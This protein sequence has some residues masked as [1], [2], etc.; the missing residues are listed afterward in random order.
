MELD[1]QWAAVFVAIAAL[2][3]AIAAYV[4]SHQAFE[5]SYRP[6]LRAIPAKA[7]PHVLILKN[8][9]RGAAVSVLIVEGSGA[10]E[11]G[12]IGQVDAIEPLGETYGPDHKESARV[13]RVTAELT[14]KLVVGAHYRV[15]Y[16]DVKGEW[17]E[18][19]FSIPDNVEALDVRMMAPR[20]ESIPLW[21]R[22][23]A[24]VVTYEP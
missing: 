1:P 9:G 8:I 2:V 24:Q 15:L 18:T 19:D 11:M 23:H 4:V 20:R 17:H 5:E 22:D 6:I 12:L 3:A 7:N 14:R 10:T 13:G 16:Q 21:A